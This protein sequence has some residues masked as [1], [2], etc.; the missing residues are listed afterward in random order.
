MSSATSRPITRRLLSHRR[1]GSFV[2]ATVMV[3]ATTAAPLAVLASP[4]AASSPLPYPRVTANSDVTHDN[5]NIA[6]LDSL[7]TI[8]VDPTDPNRLIVAEGDF[9]AGTCEVHVSTDAGV[10]WKLAPG[11]LLPKSPGFDRCTPDS[12]GLSYPMAWGASDTLLTGL[13]AMPFAASVPFTDSAPTSLVL[14]RSTDFGASFHSTVVRDN[15]PPTPKTMNNEGAWQPH[16]AVDPANR[17]VVYVA[18]QRR[19][20]PIPNF[21]DPSNPPNPDY[22]SRPAVAVST[23]GGNTFGPPIDLL[24]GQG[25]LSNIPALGHEALPTRRGPTIAVAPDGT[26]FAI[27]TQAGRPEDGPTAPA[28]QTLYTVLSVSSDHGKTF[29][30]YNVQTNTDGTDYPELAVAPNPNGKGYTLVLVYEDYSDGVAGAQQ[31]HDVFVR[32]SSDGGKTWSP[33]NRLTDDPLSDYANKFDPNVSVAP[34]GRI[35]VA[36][37]DFRND[38]GPM[39]IDVYATYS[40]NGGKTW[41]PNVRVTDRAADRRPGF[42]VDGGAVRGPVGITSDNYAAHFAWEDTRNA[43]DALP[44]QDIYAGSIQFRSL[45]APSND[46]TLVKLGAVGGGLVATALVLLVATVVAGHRPLSALAG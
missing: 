31:V 44:V 20:V 33:R 17:N 8:T 5:P 40:T 10:T 21:I 25:D 45:P 29:Q 37:Y 41:A 43:T 19:N 34:D 32:T 39:L 42:F 28:S 16:I 36:W 38:D 46:N 12:A 9:H 13:M 35:D 15:R 24:Y 3:V 27:D 6:R 22:E 30:H 4:A 2:G 23:D 1:L 26:F 7:P 14:S 11:Q 18:W